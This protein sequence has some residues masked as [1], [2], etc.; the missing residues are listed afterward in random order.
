MSAPESINDK[1]VE[2][3]IDAAMNSP[4]P[5]VFPQPADISYPDNPT[6]DNS[7]M[8]TKPLDIKEVNDNVMH[9]I[10]HLRVI[11]RLI[12][13]SEQY[14][15]FLYS[16]R[17]LFRS[18]RASKL[19]AETLSKAE[20]SQ[21]PPEERQ[22]AI[23]FKQK[24]QAAYKAHFLPTYEKI[25]NLFEFCNR[26]AKTVYSI[27]SD[28]E[29][30]PS[31]VIY[32]KLM[33]IF[34]LIWNI[35]SLKLLKTGFN[36]DLSTYK[37]AFDPKEI[38]QNAELQQI[39]VFLS[40]PQASIL[41]L[42]DEIAAD[43][44]QS[45]KLEN[46][47][48]WC[49]NLLKYFVSY[50]RDRIL[51]P[52]ER[53][54]CLC[55]IVFVLH[56]SIPSDKFSIYQVE[57]IDEVFKILKEN[58]VVPLYG[59]N[60]FVPGYTLPKV[61]G[62]KESTKYPIVKSQADLEGYK[63]TLLI[64]NNMDVYRKD[65][66]EQ[67][68][69]VSDIPRDKEIKEKKLMSLLKFIST[70]TGAIQR[71]AAFKSINTSSSSPQSDKKDAKQ[72]KY[73]LCV[74]YNYS[75]EDL[76]SLV[77]VIGMIKTISSILIT[78]EPNIVKYTNKMIYAKV[79]EYI[80]NQLERPLVRSRST[81]CKGERE[82]MEHIRDIF[83]NWGNVGD[84][85]KNLP[86]ST[87]QIKTHKI[88]PGNVPITANQLDI[89]RIQLSAMILPDSKFTAR[90]GAF[91]R[92]HFRPKHINI[93]KDFLDSTVNWYTLLSYVSTVRA[94]S[95]LSFLWLRET[96]LD[97]DDTLQF[98]VRSSL[99]FILSE[100]ILKV[101]DGAAIKPQ[102]HDNTFFPF[103]LYNDAAAT[104]INTF[105]SQ[106][107]YR[108]IEAEVSL[109][110]DMIAFT[111]SDTFYKFTRATASA[112]ELPP[113][114]LSRIVPPPNRYNVMVC[115]NRMSL[116][117]SAVDFNQVTTQKLNTKIRQE[118]ESF[119]ELLTDI[120]LAPY[121]AHRVRVARASHNLLVQNRLLM[122]DF[123]VL[124]QKARNFDNPLSI[125]SKLTAA[126]CSSLDFPHYRL[127]V[128]S[129]RLLPLSLSKG[130]TNSKDK[131][132]IPVTSKEKWVEEYATIHTHETEYIGLEHIKAIIDLCSPGELAAVVSKIMARLED[133][134]I[135]VVEVYTQ[136]AS[137]IRLL[138][139]I[140]KDDIS[141][142]FN[143]NLDAY[144]SISHPK[145]RSLYDGLRAIGNTITFLFYLES[146]LKVQPGSS[147]LAG[148]MQMISQFI[149][150]KK[151][152]FLSDGTID[153]E[154][155]MTH[156][157]FPSIWSVLEFMACSPELKNLEDKDKE[158]V[159]ILD[160]VGDGPIV[161]AHVF[162]TL[163]NQ[164]ELYKFD[165][166]CYR[167][168]QLNLTEQNVSVNDQLTKFLYNASVA[169]QCQRFA[170]LVASPYKMK[171]Q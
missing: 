58:P 137:V 50:Y 159:I 170:E 43:K 17:S 19:V 119:I 112:M 138:P 76:D 81:K 37:R 113:D 130:P 156:R 114:C 100:H 32:E 111:F 70:M 22:S 99:P 41:K 104:A 105:K 28:N 103:E 154:T 91:T 95:N 65:Y 163:C 5:E 44:K 66:S 93:T 88:E 131:V 135:K 101:G 140:S 34:S 55:A 57:C 98:P 161:A 166:I 23:E 42:Q 150:S 87:K 84:P 12:E 69:L 136:V 127:N 73:D 16:Y 133:Q 68:R 126:I 29:Y 143:F 94:A 151:E 109:C 20:N 85:N 115:Q 152:L 167:A 118:L 120:R 24:Y 15:S 67:L 63:D 40:S 7:D 39:P 45:S 2:A 142:Y 75:A 71:Q 110:V 147:F 132:S 74:K 90:V 141:G 21:L 153:L 139:A 54:T 148:V 35:D 52:D 38:S 123:D 149:L 116:L 77:E 33:K 80:Q 8:V 25:K 27:I 59:E 82:L 134:M 13:E 86:K 26:F 92:S 102:L 125:D 9:E 121:I 11:S 3:A 164:E 72:Y 122:D 165:S 97:I 106:Y 157:S 36:L 158:P 1:M 169:E 129:R 56:L 53:S 78:S 10:N 128:I 83:G 146:E 6:Y 96:Y 64:R 171:I 49:A 107:L 48:N 61:P 145:L 144:S 30:T 155:T 162:I 18:T 117:G 4:L 79:Q 160:Y 62:F 108:E 168:T 31:G 89:L 47:Y 14:I 60:S 51:T 46:V 124:W